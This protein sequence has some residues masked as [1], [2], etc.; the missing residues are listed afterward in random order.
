M[1]ARYLAHV[2]AGIRPLSIVAV[3]FT[4]RAASELRH[5]I[6]SQMRERYLANDPRVLEV[7]VAPIGTI[8][9]LCQRICGEFPVESGADFDFQVVDETSYQKLLTLEMPHLLERIPAETYELLDYSTLKSFVTACL[10]DLERFRTSAAVDIS[11]VKE[12]ISAAQRAAIDAGPWA[13]IEHELSQ[14]QALRTSDR[15]ELARLEALSGLRSLRQGDGQGWEVLSHLNLRGGS[16]KNWLAGEFD[17]IKE[18]LRGLRERIKELP[19]YVRIG[20]NDT[21]TEHQAAILA[22]TEAVEIV[23]GQ[24]IDLKARR[25]IVDFSDLETHALQALAN[26]AVRTELADRWQAILVDE[27]Q[28][29][30]PIQ[31]QILTSLGRDATL[32]AVGDA[33]QS[34]YRFRGADPELFSQQIAASQEHVTLDENYRTI[35]ALVDSINATF[36]E[37]IPDYEALHPVRTTRYARNPVE[38]FVVD[39][40]SDATMPQRRKVL[41]EQIGYRILSLLEEPFEVADPETGML[42]QTQPRDIAVISASWGMLDLVAEELQRLQLPA[43]IVGGGP[44]LAT[45]EALDVLT[46]LSFCA[47][48]HE[49]LACLALVRSPMLG[50]SDAELA[51]LGAAKPRSKSWFTFLIDHLGDDPRL[52]PISRLPFSPTVMSP[53]DQLAVAGDLLLYPEII[54][55]LNH[56]ERRRAD[57]TALLDLVD[58]R[59][60]EGLDTHDIV[61]YLRFAIDHEARIPRPPVDAEDSI[62]LVT[63]HASKGLEWPI[64]I[65]TDLDR[66]PRKTP[67]VAVDPRYGIAYKLQDERSG[68]LSWIIEQQKEEELAEERRR[69]YVATTRARDHLILALASTDRVGQLLEQFAQQTEI[70]Q[71]RIDANP[72]IPRVVSGSGPPRYRLPEV[73]LAMPSAHVQHRLTSR[74]LNDFRLC[75]LLLATPEAPRGAS[76]RVRMLFLELAAEGRPFNPGDLDWLPPAQAESLI[77]KAAEY[78]STLSSHLVAAPELTSGKTTLAQWSVDWGPFLFD[79]ASI[80]DLTMTDGDVVGLS[81]AH[82]EHPGIRAGIF[83][84]AQS[85]IHW[86]SSRELTSIHRELPPLMRELAEPPWRAR[87]DRSST[88]RFCRQANSC[89]WVQREGHKL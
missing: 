38:V 28:D 2:D 26:E 17:L 37:L 35:P 22:L 71:V 76:S 1:A 64:T 65:V 10:K 12:L 62:S 67:S 40:T 89:H 46:L 82:A 45:Q 16:T 39:E 18:S 72:A 69:W 86:L 87:D 84:L 78:Q 7:Q 66:N 15:I 3:T 60:N 13:A 27:V 85:R 53:S 73:D 42:R 51:V 6:L 68:H 29:I 57:W 49:D 9:S 33:K 61:A 20:W 23:A 5:R 14:Y 30:S 59:A 83:Y 81:L 19:D 70:V 52:R 80:I 63:I 58:Q 50:L 41:S 75:P 77:S 54:T 21:D 4:I 74:S 11:K 25:H 36:T 56:P 47:N 24:L 79:G 44:L 31:Y 88:C 55:R 32:S 8:H 43:N 48:P 34:L